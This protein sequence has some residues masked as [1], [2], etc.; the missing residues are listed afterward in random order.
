[1]NQQGPSRM[2]RTQN[3]KAKQPLVITVP[4]GLLRRSLQ[5]VIPSKNLRIGFVISGSEIKFLSPT[6]KWDFDLSSI[7]HLPH[8]HYAGFRNLRS[9]SPPIRHCYEFPTHGEYNASQLPTCP[10][11]HG[12]PLP[13]PLSPRYRIN[14]F[15]GSPP[16]RIY[17]PVDRQLPQDRKFVSKLAKRRG[18]IIN[19]LSG[20]LTIVKRR[21]HS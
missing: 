15:R 17:V 21:T 2:K 9:P 12:R 4:R 3:M 6:E 16:N 13:A 1:M 5:E 14:P 11:E 19:P 7:Q 10:P 18:V 20:K 8:S